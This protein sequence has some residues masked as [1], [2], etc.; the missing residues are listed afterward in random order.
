MSEDMAPAGGPAMAAPSAPAAPGAP[1]AWPRASSRPSPGFAWVPALM[2]GYIIGRDQVE[3][4]HG[5]RNPAA[6]NILRALLVVIGVGAMLFL[7]AIVFGLLAL[8]IVAL[9]A[10]SE[11]IAGNTS[12]ADQGIARTL[13]AITTVAIWLVVFFVVKPNINL[14][15]G[16]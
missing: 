13:V 1:S 9:M 12:A 6:T 5:V 11:R 4:M 8:L 14:S 15:I 16:G 2:V 10:F 7:G 3:R